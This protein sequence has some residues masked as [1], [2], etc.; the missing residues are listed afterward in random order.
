MSESNLKPYAVRADRS[1][2]RKHPEP[3][4]SPLHRGEHGV[5]DRYDEAHD[6][7]ALDRHRIVHSAAFRR[8][9][10]K[11]Q[12]FVT[13]EHDH[14][15]TRLTHT[16]EVADIARRLACAL[17][18]NATLAEAIALAHDL[19]HPPF[20]H[21][22][23]QALAAR[24]G[25]HGGFE[26]NVQS[27]RIVEYLEHPYPPFRGLNLTHEVRE[28]LAKHETKFDR[29]GWHELIDGT[30]APIEAQI[31]SVA[32]RIAYDCH[33]LED[34]IGAKF[35]DGRE[36]EGVPL[37]RETSEPTFG[38]YGHRPLPAVR[39]PILDA[40]EEALLADI[41]EETTRRVRAARVQTADDVRAAGEDLVALSGPMA[42]KLAVL[43]G[44]LLTHLYRHHR[45]IRMDDKAR[46]FI[47]RL[48]DAYVQTPGLLEPRFAERIPEQGLHRVVCDY[49]AGM[50][51][52]FCQD[53]Y[54]RLFEP[55]ERV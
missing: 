19:G 29:P 13:H 25:E 20:G 26:H 33:D 41:V 40:L 14:F 42:E 2:G 44:F 34:A 17:S 49:V 11:T 30:R 55:F 28:G 45:L 50:T 1:V 6:A 18:V 12:V 4:P 31:A 22:G 27:L 21:A 53:E 54:K 10:Y 52:R 51:D 16:L 43:E 48:F 39:R 3:A 32:D 46:R 23:E 37:W 7:F 35:V 15:R 36:L 9:Q 24:M 38:Q 8:L 47:D 5:G